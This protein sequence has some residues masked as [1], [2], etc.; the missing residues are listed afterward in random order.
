MMMF[1][2]NRVK[3]NHY[4][5]IILFGKELELSN[6]VK[7]LGVYLDPR[8]S[9]NRHIEHIRQKANNAM[10]AMCA[11]CQ[12]C[13]GLTPKM[14]SYIYN[15]IILPRMTYGAI[16][17]W[18]RLSEDNKGT[19][20]N[21]I[22]I[23]RA[24]RRIAMMITGAMRT[25]PGIA[26]CALL[27]MTPIDLMITRRAMEAYFRL[28][29]A[30]AWERNGYIEG[31]SRISKLTDRFMSTSE[32]NRI[33]PTW[34]PSKRF[35]V[36]HEVARNGKTDCEMSVYVDAAVAGNRAGI[37]L[38]CYDLNIKESLKLKNSSDIISAETL[39][40]EEAA[41][42]CLKTGITNKTIAFF[43]DS[44]EALKRIEAS[45][46]RFRT[47]LS[48]VNTLNRLTSRN[49]RVEVRWL[50]KRM[51]KY[52][53][54]EADRLAKAAMHRLTSQVDNPG[55]EDEEGNSILEWVERRTNRRW[56]EAPFENIKVMFNGFG[57]ERTTGILRFCKK[58]LRL[59]TYL[60]TS[61]AP[62]RSFLYKMGRSDT[63]NCR[64]CKTPGAKETTFHILTDCEADSIDMARRVN[65]GRGHLEESELAELS[66]KS[67][68]TFA[69]HIKLDEI[70]G[71]CRQAVQNTSRTESVENT[72][73]DIVVL[74]E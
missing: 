40:I 42:I 60:L 73:E 59:L 69:K 61:H 9:M 47:T 64:F 16:V 44:Q 54:M 68:L 34:L 32:R 35:S 19:K 6:E 50:P 36:L 8:L 45:E 29:K 24:Q 7:Y 49:R 4:S 28:E 37:G 53:H 5:N 31:H 26:L 67:L 20:T 22:S 1:T 23:G 48:C 12:K 72:T 39:A 11:L 15:A 41:Q 55:C 71:I 33:E 2:R 27:K 43:T 52:Q 56:E 63:P 70:T 10:W 30:G 62:I 17:F 51:K 74:E 14:I 18:H 38:V 13:W 21:I 25:T 66:V 57:D 65:F 3:A 58:D 46:T